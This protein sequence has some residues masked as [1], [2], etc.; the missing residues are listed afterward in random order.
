MK[1]GEEYKCRKCGRLTAYTGGRPNVLCPKCYK[2]M[3]RARIEA[4]KQRRSEE[5]IAKVRHQK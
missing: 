1:V 2:E 5:K 4:F 3:R